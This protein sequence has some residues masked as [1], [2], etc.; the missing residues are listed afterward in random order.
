[1]GIAGL[2]SCAKARRTSGHGLGWRSGVAKPSDYT[3]G[4]R[5]Y[6]RFLMSLDIAAVQAALREDGLDGWLLYDFRAVS[7]THLTLPTT[8]RV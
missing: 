3:A 2:M 5:C 6:T 4:A 8:S 7:Y 1:M